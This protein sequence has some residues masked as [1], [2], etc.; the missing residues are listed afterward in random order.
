MESSEYQEGREAF[1]NGSPEEA[2]PYGPKRHAIN[3]GSWE[4]DWRWGWEDAQ[5]EAREGAHG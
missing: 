4:R 2:N 3:F 5:K 1:V